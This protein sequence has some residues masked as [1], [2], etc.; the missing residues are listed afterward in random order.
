LE[1][2]LRRHLEVIALTSARRDGGMACVKIIAALVAGLAGLAAPAFAYTAAGDR[3]FPASILLPQIAPS[4]D[5]YLTSGTQPLHSAA[6]PSS[7]DRLTNASVV[8]NK[9]ITER[10]S[11]GIEDGW[12][13]FDQAGAGTASGWQNL[14]TTVKYLAVLDPRHEFLLAVGADREWGGT[15]A[16]GVGA[17]RSGAI[18]P[19][20]FFGKGMGD[21]DPA[22]LRPFAVVGTVGYQLADTHSRPD[23]L[24]AGIAI[25]YS[26]PY[27]ESKV[28]ALAL[29]DFA[30][31]LTPIV[32]LQFATPASATRGAATAATV[33]PGFNYAG[34][35]WELGLA[36][37]VPATRAA[38]SGVGIIAQF[39]LSLDYLFP[40]SIGRPLFARH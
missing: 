35:G 23:L 1:R 10:L 11:V 22:F 28:A 13:R 37:L 36:A 16:A 27:L 20:L 12:N 24:V 18:T 34:E 29:P 26:L 17:S 31:K 7:S 3:L 40:D 33:A 30:R 8:F 9:T 5:A 6:L 2:R 4:D 14:E 19:A 21:L 15:G 38:G 25:Q 39:H 32:E